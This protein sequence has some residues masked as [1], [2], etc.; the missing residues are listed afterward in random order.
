MVFKSRTA[1]ATASTDFMLFC[2]WFR[3]LM[4]MQPIQFSKNCVNL[5]NP[6]VYIILS[7]FIIYASTWSYFDV[8]YL[9][10]TWFCFFFSVKFCTCKKRCKVIKLGTS[11]DI[12]CA[13]KVCIFLF[14]Y[15]CMNC[16]LLF[17]FLKTWY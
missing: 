16:I 4:N 5:L 1:V 9:T 10:I 11:L 7:L 13:H 8:F 12:C 14:Y 6:L 15:V 3:V 2:R 17:Y